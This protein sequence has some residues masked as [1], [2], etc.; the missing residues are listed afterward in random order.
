[1]GGEGPQGVGEGL[2]WW[3]NGKDPRVLVKAMGETSRDCGG[4]G[5]NPGGEVA[6]GETPMMGGEGRK[7]HW[8]R[9][10]ETLGGDDNHSPPQNGERDGR[11][12]G[13]GKGQR[14]LG[15]GE[16]NGRSL[17]GPEW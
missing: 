16:G 1:M 4:S 8:G 11:D 3:G 5:R 15:C 2:W 7:Q 9:Q 13:G 17:W 12:P 14:A 10:W 6:T